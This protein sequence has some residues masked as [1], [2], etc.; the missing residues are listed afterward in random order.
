VGRELAKPRAEG[1]TVQTSALVPTEQIQHRKTKEPLGPVEA[2]GKKEVMGT[3]SFEAERL[4]MNS[5]CRTASGGRPF[6]SLV[7][8]SAGLETYDIECN[9]QRLTVRCEVRSCL[10]VK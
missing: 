1:S 7:E 5:G 3:Q 9:N 2:K 10:L 4:A 8:N 6:A